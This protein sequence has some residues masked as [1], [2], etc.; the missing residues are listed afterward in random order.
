[1]RIT[2]ALAFVLVTT[3][4]AGIRP[5]LRRR[6]TASADTPG[7]KVSETLKVVKVGDSVT[8]TAKLVGVPEGTPTGGPAT[9]IVLDGDRF[10]YK[11]S[12]GG[13]LVITYT[14]VVSG[15]TFTGEGAIGGIKVPYNGVRTKK[16][17]ILPGR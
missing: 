13:D 2:A 9:D 7:G 4:A 17:G 14:G 11:R 6:W 16:A 1:M 3:F 5:V 15:D 10:S 8:I 12:V